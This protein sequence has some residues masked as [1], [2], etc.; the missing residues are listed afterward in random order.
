MDDDPFAELKRHQLTPEMRA[1]VPRKIQKRQRRFVMVPW[2][3]FERLKGVKS[4]QTY[5]VAL[6]LLYMGWKD[7]GVP[8]KLTSGMLRIDGISRKSKWM[9]LNALERHGLIAVERRPRRSPIVR[10]LT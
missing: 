4:V 3:W 10:L 5:R 8:I 1:V 2:S 6:V 7:R 9:A